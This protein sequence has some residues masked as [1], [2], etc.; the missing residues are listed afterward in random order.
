MYTIERKKRTRKGKYDHLAN[1]KPNT[2]QVF[3]VK[4]AAGIK[5]ALKRLQLA[6]HFEVLTAGDA[7]GL[8]EDSMSTVGAGTVVVIRVGE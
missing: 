1:M 3:E 4:S 5:S 6:E 2:H 7:F 8:D